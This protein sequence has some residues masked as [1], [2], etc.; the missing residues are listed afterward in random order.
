[1]TSVIIIVI[2]A[3]VALLAFMLLQPCLVKISVAGQRKAKLHWDFSLLTKER[4][5]SRIIWSLIGFLAL[6]YCASLLLPLVWMF[7]TSFKDPIEYTISTFAFTKVWHFDNYT[8]VFS[9]LNNITE[10]IRT[11]GMGEML[12][13]SAWYAVIVNINAIFWT[14]AVAYV[15]A[16][17]QFIGNKF[18]YSLGI[19][20]MLVPIVGTGMS[21][22]IFFQKIGLYDK[23]YIST[24]IPPS[25]P[26]SGMNFMMIYA[27]FKAI[28]HDYSDAARID[29]AN[30][31]RIMFQIVGPM[32]LPTMATFFILGFV[33]SWNAYETFLINYPSTPNLAFGMWKFQSGTG[34][35]A[36][37]GG[38]TIP[39]ILAGFV[40]CMIP[41]AILYLS[42]QKLIYSKFT[43][44]GLKG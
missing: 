36:G 38:A 8:K 33:N 26:F 42:S 15:M 32:V 6:S 11:Y 14:S 3:Y 34:A 4:A 19:I 20:I 7:Y 41:S 28:P 16:R 43:V 2:V 23:M 39:Q 31:Y 10:G 35:T 44:G 13:N 22:I 24:L 37:S 27:A 9:M 30:E 40:I 25:T 18:V 17:F 1:M 12:F 5:I 21:N 29:G